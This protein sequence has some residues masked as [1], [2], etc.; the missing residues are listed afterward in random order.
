[1]HF[2]SNDYIGTMVDQNSNSIQYTYYAGKI[3]MSSRDGTSITTST[4][5]FIATYNENGRFLGV[6]ILTEPGTVSVTGDTAK[7][8]WINADSFTPK[9]E[10]AKIDLN[11]H[12]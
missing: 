8:F 6:Q 11:G 1:M 5:V 9:A 10:A 7:L 2:N 4:P 3:T 12:D